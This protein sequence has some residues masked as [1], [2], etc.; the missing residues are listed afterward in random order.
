VEDHEIRL[1]GGW[2]CTA[3]D[4]SPGPRR[5]LTLPIRW[6]SFTSGRF[7][8]TRRFSRPPRTPDGPAILR[9]RQTPGLLSILFNGRPLGPISPE[10]S[11][12]EIALGALAP[13]NEIVLEIA[14]TGEN[15]EWGL[16]SLIFVAGP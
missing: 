5:R 10:L 14:P 9:L 11:E 12:Y 3:L 8:L 1:R 13:R 16:I 15:S 4:G 6:E 2:E 7:R